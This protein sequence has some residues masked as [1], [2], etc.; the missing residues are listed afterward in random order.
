MGSPFS[1]V[2]YYFRIKRAH[3]KL[4]FLSSLGLMLSAITFSR[5]SFESGCRDIGFEA[6]PFAVA[7]RL[8]SPGLIVV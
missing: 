3:E 4:Y 1:C 2:V 5:S 6:A 8:Q 7:F